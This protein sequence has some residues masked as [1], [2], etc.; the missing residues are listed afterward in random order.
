MVDAGCTHC[1]MEASSHAIVQHRV[2]G[3]QL[4]GAVFTNITHDHLDYHGTF[5]AYIKAKKLLFDGLP[6]EAFALVNTDDK[7]GPVMVQN[8]KARKVTFA[9]KQPADYKAR[10]VSNSLQGLE[11]ELD[12]Q[13]VWFKLIGSFNAYNI[14]AGYAV[15]SLLDEQ[16][17]EVLRQ[18]SGLQPVDGRFEQVAPETGIM[19]IVDYAH[20]PDAL[21]NVLETITDFRTGNE[22]LITLVGCG[23][24]RDHEKRPKMAEIACRLSDKVILTSD[25]PRDEAPEAI[26]KDMQA[27][28]SAANY[29]KTMVVTD[30]KEAI[31]VAAGM[32][33]PG[34][35]IL[36]AGKGHETYQ[37]VQGQRFPFDDKQVLTEMLRLMRE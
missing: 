3:I 14:L 2:T 4:A 19:A 37:E 31:K 11:L 9:L 29:K 32:A 16:A 23:G 12:N 10:I 24:N 25:N 18:L 21:Q 6:A 26:I 28:V 33:N 20:T 27:G 5:D 1:F 35:I 15:A 8:T 30:R 36:L 13:N 17:D 34:D 7:R 22:Q